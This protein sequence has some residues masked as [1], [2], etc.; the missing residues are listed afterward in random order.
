MKLRITSAIRRRRIIV[1]NVEHIEGLVRSLY[2]DDECVINIYGTK[3]KIQMTADKRRARYWVWLNDGWR[4]KSKTVTTSIIV[5]DDTGE[6]HYDRDTLFEMTKSGCGHG[7]VFDPANPP[8]HKTTQVHSPTSYEKLSLRQM[9]TAAVDYGIDIS[10]VNE[11]RTTHLTL[12]GVH[13]LCNT[14]SRNSVILIQSIAELIESKKPC[15]R[16]AT[17]SLRQSIK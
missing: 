10:E 1:I 17:M 11:R 3:I 15:K 9:Q 14:G 16:C 5:G 12:D 13:T 6:K 8:I 7:D 4:N 2:R